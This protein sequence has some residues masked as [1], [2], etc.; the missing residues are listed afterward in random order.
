[1]IGVVA[2][3]GICLIVAGV[4][5]FVVAMFRSV[6]SRD[7]WK[8]WQTLAI[9]FLL[10]VSSPYIWTEV[11]TKQKGKGMKAAILD[12]LSQSPL[13]G[14]LEYYK[15]LKTDGGKARVVAVVSENEAGVGTQRAVV[16]MT[17]T[18]SGNSWQAEKF[19]IVNS[20]RLN[21]DGF[22]MPPFY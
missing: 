6:Q 16:E 2:Y 9:F 17:L 14:K 4:L 18:K 5:T 11:Q 8:S 7:D 20:D 21:K 22:T 3:L 12:G 15:V 1:M 10:V 19:K 13:D